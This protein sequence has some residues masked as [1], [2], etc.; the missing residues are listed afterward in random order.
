MVNG[1][2]RGLDGGDQV[3]HAVHRVQVRRG[4][5]DLRADVAVDAGDLQAGQR[6]RM[7]VN[8]YSVFMRHAELVALQARRDVGMGLGVDIGIDTDADRRHLAQGHGD[9][10]QHI[11][12]GFAFDVEAADAGR[13][14]L[15]H[16]GAGLAHARKD[17]LAYIA[18]CGQHALELAARDD[19]ETA[20]GLCKHL[21]H[22]QRGIGFHGVADLGVASC[23][24]LLIGRQRCQHRGFGIHKQRR[25]VFTRQRVKAGFFQVQPALPVGQLG[26]ARQ[27][28]GGRDGGGHPAHRGGRAGA[29][30]GGAAGGGCGMSGVA[31]GD[32]TGLTG[33]AGAAPAEGSAFGGGGEN[34]G[35]FWPQAVRPAAPASARA[36]KP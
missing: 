27:C 21:Q 32:P 17:H 24:A 8:P 30:V 15:L 11:Q 22:A 35:P 19:V 12:L 25:A 29:E 1:D 10:G 5:G 33:V 31:T 7:P 14:R 26:C 36:Q 28:G 9:P 16:F 13:Q 4:F 3:Q 2:A 23:K 34:S 20:T 6:C 18:A